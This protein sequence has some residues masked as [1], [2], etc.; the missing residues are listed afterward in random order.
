MKSRMIKFIWIQYIFWYIL[1]VFTKSQASTNKKE[2]IDLYN[3]GV[4]AQ[5]EGKLS[6][7]IEKYKE[8]IGLL[9]EFPEAHQNLGIL[10]ES[11]SE[12]DAAVYHHEQSIIFSIDNAFKSSAYVNLVL[13]HL[14]ATK[15]KGKE[16]HFNLLSYLGIFNY[17]Y[18]M[19][20]YDYLIF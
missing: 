13:T 7:A 14:K 3:L 9:N 17:I 18:L 6:V 15:I 5:R 8:A 11:I 19:I 4:S 10:M 20:D 12:L 1:L 16:F 2:A